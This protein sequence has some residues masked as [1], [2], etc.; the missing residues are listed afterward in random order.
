MWA[1]K[2]LYLC[3][4]KFTGRLPDCWGTL[5][6]LEVLDLRRN[7]LKGAIPRTFGQLSSLVQLDLSFNQFSGEVPVERFASMSKLQWLNL[8]HCNFLG[9]ERSQRDLQ[10]F[11]PNA[12]VRIHVPEKIFIRSPLPIFPRKERRV[13]SA[14][15][16][17]DIE[18][19]LK[20]D[21]T[22]LLNADKAEIYDGDGDDDLDQGLERN[23]EENEDSQNEDDE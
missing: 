21:K 2:Q 11:H 8:S 10:S 6:A 23:K 5:P 19:R 18:S 22:S 15:T 13:G 17:P 16:V 20:S 3:D 12:V 7:S 9:T 14:S 4:N 1:L